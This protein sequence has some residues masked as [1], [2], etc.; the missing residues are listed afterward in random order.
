[1][2]YSPKKPPKDLKKKIKKK[3]PKASAKDIRQF[4]HIFNS[5]IKAGDPESKAFSK[6]WGSLKKKKAKKKSMVL[7]HL[8]K[9]ASHLDQ[10]GFY[11]E[12]DVIDLLLKSLKTN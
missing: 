2:P 11:T 3:Y 7:N 10:N 5:S 12:A 1:M 4:I 9:L 6:A 8:T